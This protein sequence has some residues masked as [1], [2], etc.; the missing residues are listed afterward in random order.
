MAYN[1]KR[2]RKNKC[3]A[4]DTRH[5][6]TFQNCAPSSD[7]EGG[8][9]DGWID[10]LTV[11]GSVNPVKASQEMEYKSI[12]TETTYLIKVRGNVDCNDTQQIKFN[13]RYFEILTIENI[14]ERQIEKQIFCK[15]VSR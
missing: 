9:I 2:I 15:E 14:Q 10:V 12:S 7:G 4:S 1:L 11:W 8:F 5:R 13:N 3:L 6:I